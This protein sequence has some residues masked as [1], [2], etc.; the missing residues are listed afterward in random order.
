MPE[1]RGPIDHNLKTWPE[2][3]KGLCRGGRRAELRKDDRDFRV[4]DYLRLREYDPATMEYSG[5]WMMFR[6]THVVRAPNP[7]LQPGYAMLSLS[8]CL[9]MDKDSLS[10]WP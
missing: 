1:T 7:G 3:Y 2:S 10:R 4:N 8:E 5:H 6:V 9:A